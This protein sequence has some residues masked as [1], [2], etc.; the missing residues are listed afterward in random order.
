MSRPVQ[1]CSKRVQLCPH[2]LGSVQAA[3]LGIPFKLCSIFK[4]VQVHIQ[5]RSSR[6]VSIP[7]KLW[8]KLVRIRSSPFSPFHKIP[9]PHASKS[10]HLRPSPLQSF[11]Q[12]EDHNEENPF[13][14]RLSLEAF[15]FRCLQPTSRPFNLVQNLF[16]SVQ[17]SSTPFNFYFHEFTGKRDVPCGSCSGT[18]PFLPLPFTG[19]ASVHLPFFFSVHFSRPLFPFKCVRAP[20]TPAL[21]SVRSCPIPFK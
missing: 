3:S 6:A 18:I 8:F 16:K 19:E 15:F 10:V 7:F 14:S 5:V 11:F 2:P 13:G 17:M 1:F 9:V 20:L 4:T 12:L 21:N